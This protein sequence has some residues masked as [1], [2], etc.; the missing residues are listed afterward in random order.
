VKQLILPTARLVLRTLDPSFAAR[1]L[2]YHQR[3]R[4]F[5]RPWN[6]AADDSYYTLAAHEERLRNDALLFEQGRGVRF[7]LFA[8]DDPAFE[9]VIGD[10]GLANVVR[11]AFQ[12]CHLGY[13]MDE[14]C[15]SRGLM[16]EALQAA[17]AF[18]FDE[19]KLH[20]VEA[21]VMP[22]N[23]RSIR[24]VEKLGFHCEGLART[25]LQINGVWEDHL[26]FAL[27]NP[28]YAPVTG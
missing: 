6:P 26:H 8:A 16:T 19:L 1:V 17:I 27:I 7:W 14:T 15:G 21:N 23:G 10:I 12:S 2:D 9:T 5:F 11:G 24:V 3:N 18:A 22:R 28:D 20:R 13:K 4:A 25:Y